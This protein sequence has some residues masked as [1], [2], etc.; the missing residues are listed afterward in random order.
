MLGDLRD[1]TCSFLERGYLQLVERPH[2]LPRMNR[3][4]KD[5]LAGRTIYRD[6]EY[7]AYK[8]A[9]E[10]DGIAYHRGSRARAADSVRDLETLATRDEVTVRLTPHQVFREGCRSGHLIGRIL[11]GRG[12]AGRAI[13][14]PACN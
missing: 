2:G 8:L 10:L 1:G 9:V 12:W 7:A 11:Q 4:A 6:G 14:C 5:V 3:Q 13:R